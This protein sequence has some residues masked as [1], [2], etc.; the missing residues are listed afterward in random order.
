MSAV[1]YIFTRHY[2]YTLNT[3]IS[4]DSYKY[5]DSSRSLMRAYTKSI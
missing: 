3:L 2:F 1:K 5:P 4:I